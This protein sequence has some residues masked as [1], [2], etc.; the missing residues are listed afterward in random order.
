LRLSRAADLAADHVGD[1]LL[2]LFTLVAV[3]SLLAVPLIYLLG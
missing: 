2:L 1:V 3:G